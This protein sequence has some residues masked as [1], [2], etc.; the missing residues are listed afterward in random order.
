MMLGKD[1][2]NRFGAASQLAVKAQVFLSPTYPC[3][4]WNLALS[5]MHI[6]GWYTATACTSLAS[7]LA[8]YAMWGKLGEPQH[9]LQW[10]KFKTIGRI[11]GVTNIN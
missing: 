4:G 10:T 1:K 2:P 3:D 7:R 5:G 11:L 9:E 6:Y 8:V